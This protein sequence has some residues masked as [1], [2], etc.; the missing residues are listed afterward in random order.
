MIALVLVFVLMLVSSAV[1][2]GVAVDAADGDGGERLTHILQAAA[3]R[4]AVDQMPEA[5]R[6][7]LDST[8]NDPAGTQ[9][10]R[11]SGGRLFAPGTS[12]LTADGRETVRAFGRVLAESSTWRRIRVEGH[13][14]VTQPG[15]LDDWDSSALFASA[16]VRELVEGAELEPW[17]LAVAGRGGQVPL[18]QGRDDPQDERVEIVVEYCMGEQ[19]ARDEVQGR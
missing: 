16:V 3:L 5:F 7:V 10:W 11:F 4:A 18:E 6:P 13:T 2:D 8:R 17:W 12:D 14:R 15:E 1:V 19:C 9:R